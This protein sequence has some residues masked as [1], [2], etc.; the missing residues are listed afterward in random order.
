MEEGSSKGIP[1][2]T[3]GYVDSLT[4]PGDRGTIPG[5]SGAG[6]WVLEMT[7]TRHDVR[8]KAL[9]V[10]IKYVIIYTYMCVLY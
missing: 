3:N 10:I 5:F 6:Q 2:A 1:L 4:L 9:C 7:T 8:V